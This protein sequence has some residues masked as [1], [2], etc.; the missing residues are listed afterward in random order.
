MTFGDRLYTDFNTEV[1]IVKLRIPLDKLSSTPAFYRQASDSPSI[2]C[3]NSFSSYCDLI[4]V[5]SI[6]IH[7]LYAFILK[8]FLNYRCK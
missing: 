7:S 4:L 5:Y 8:T 3:N 6:Y 2:S 1:K